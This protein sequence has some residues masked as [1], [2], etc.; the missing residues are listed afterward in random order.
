MEIYQANIHD[1]EGT[2]HL[3]NLYRMFYNQESDIEGALA[4]IKER[5]EDADSVI[6]IVKDNE[7]FLGFTQLYPTFSSIS[8]K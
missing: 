6:F 3:F 5:I 7:K 4:Y 8:I 2:A 1:L